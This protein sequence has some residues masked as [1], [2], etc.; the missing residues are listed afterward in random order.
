MFVDQ[1]TPHFSKDNEEVNVHV[2][3]LQAMLDATIVADP[4]HDQEDDDQGHEDDHQQ[5]PRGDSACSITPP[6]EHGRG[7][8]RDNYDLCDVICGRDARGR[9]ENRH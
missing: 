5:S 2:K 3:H 8:G 4:V 9:I 1:I 6:E 7:H